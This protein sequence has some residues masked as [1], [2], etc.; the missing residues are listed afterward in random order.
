M[1]NYVNIKFLGSD[2]CDVDVEYEVIDGDDSVGLAEDY[3]F[4]AT[5][6]DE[7]DNVVDI[8]D[9]LTEEEQQEVI[10]AIQKD[11]QKTEWD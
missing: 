3:E 7:A 2:Y 4:T 6:V 10:E 11:M 8:T 9:D 5:V 1:I